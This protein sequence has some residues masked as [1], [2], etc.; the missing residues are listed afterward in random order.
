MELETAEVESP[1]NEETSIENVSTDDLRNALGITEQAPQEEVVPEPEGLAEEPQPEAEGLEPEVESQE[2]EEE[3]LAKRRIRPRNEL[4]QQV[5]DL[6]RS[7]GFSGSFADASRVIYGQ[8]VQTPQA[9][10]STPQEVEAAKPDPVQGIDKQADD[11]RAS[12]VELEGKVDTAAEDLETTDALR[13]QR[14]IM[15]RELAL[16]NLLS[17][18]ER[19]VEANNEHI[20]QTHRGKAMGSRDRVYERYPALQDADS[21]VRKQFD[22]YV[23]QAQSDPDYAAVFDSPKWPE[24]VANEFASLTGLGAGVPVQAP[25]QQAPQMGTQAKVLTTGTAAQPVNAPTTPAGLIQQLPSMSKNDLYSLLGSPGGA[26][27]MR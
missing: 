27:P 26:S 6:Y 3:K 9:Q 20:Y 25:L 24:L 8:D 18:K 19:M 23:A 14:E 10:I 21:V 12:I 13:F 2:S 16:Q 22:D 11:L 1:Q 17:R 4:D 15:K 5:I 7:E